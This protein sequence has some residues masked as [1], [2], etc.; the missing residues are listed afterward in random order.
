MNNQLTILEAKF[1][2][3]NGPPSGKDILLTPDHGLSTFQDNPLSEKGNSSKDGTAFIT[4][5]TRFQLSRL[6]CLSVGADNPVEWLRKC[7]SFFELHQV[8]IPYRTHLAT[9]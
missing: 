3:M 5:D 9:L 4:R 7:C 6:D 2:R 1:D 8:L